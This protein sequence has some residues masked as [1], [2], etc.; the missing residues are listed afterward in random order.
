MIT[1][2]KTVDGREIEISTLKQLFDT[3]YSQCSA[4]DNE[5]MWKEIICFEEFYIGVNQ[6]N[7]F[8]T[9]IQFHVGGKT[10]VHCW[11]DDDNMKFQLV[12]RGYYQNVG[13]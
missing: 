11:L 3:V 12:N 2:T 9:A 7:D 1:T 10:D 8:I 5:W 6:V 4:R 13:A